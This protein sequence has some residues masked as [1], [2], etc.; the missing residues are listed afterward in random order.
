MTEPCGPLCRPAA[1]RHGVRT[2]PGVV[3]LAMLA[4]GAAGSGRTDEPTRAEEDAFRAAVARV[5]GAVVR[6]EPGTS[7]VAVAGDAEGGP[8]TGPSTG[9]VIDD[10]ATADRSWIVTTTL[11]VPDGVE[12]VVVVRPDSTRG[13]GRVVGRDRARALALLQ[14]PRID[15]VPVP[16][17]APR[18]ELEPGQWAIAVGRGWNQAGPGVSV[19]IVSATDRCWGRAVQTDAAVSPA[20]YGGPLVDLE[21]RVIGLLAPL[22][23]DTAGM[24]QGTELYDSGIGFAV[25]LEDV[26]RVL[27]RLKEGAT[28]VPG[29]LGITWHGTDLINGPPLI[30]SCRSGSPAALA[31]LRAGDRIVEVAGRPIGRIADARHQLGPRYAGDE[32]DVMVERPAKGGGERLTVRIVLADRLPPWRRAMVGV[33]PLTTPAGVPVAKEH[34]PAVHGLA[35]D[36]VLAGGPADKA[37]IRAGDR[38]TSIRPVAAAGGDAAVPITTRA[39]LVAVLAG[40]EPTQPVTIGYLRADK[41]VT[42]EVVTA[43]PP[44]DPTVGLAAALNPQDRRAGGAGGRPG[45]GVD[46]ATIVTLDVAEDRQRPLAVLPADRGVA[47]LPLVIYCGPPRGPLD[48]G[49]AAPWK[50]AVAG[51]GVA[52]LLPGSLDPQRWGPA[53]L[54]AIGRGVLALDARRPIDRSRIAIAGS[55]AGGTFAWLVAERFGPQARGVAMLDAALPRQ[56]M[57]EPVDPLR[58]KWVL[59][60]AGAGTT[61]RHL[62]VDA[63]KRRLTAAGYAVGVVPAD[64]A[65]PPAEL[66]C[67]WAVMLGLL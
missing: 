2:S 57:I 19:G 18:R 45:G 12:R 33:L 13:V 22:P 66:L 9:L 41:A 32:V 30:G 42:A 48:E 26:L 65:G 53:D 59:F 1:R 3:V 55:Q 37:G 54:A 67:R 27:P 51:N 50:A 10:D 60:G 21:G 38:I 4:A 64:D 63:D 23:A 31:G 56:A 24:N 61:D 34:D 29:I 6:L 8:S 47:P 40:I 39:D 36:R 7:A 44:L 46:A 5:A 16:K 35:V 15:A 62:R 11:A 14:T 52:V 17:P 25:P 28:L 58:W 20:N 49:A 43:E